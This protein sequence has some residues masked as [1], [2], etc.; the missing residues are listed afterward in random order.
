MEPKSSLPCS[1]EPATDPYPG[2]DEK[3]HTFYPNHFRFILILSPHLH[4]GLPSRAF[5]SGFP[6]KFCYAFLVASMFGTCSDHI[7]SLI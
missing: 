7:I 2:P 5:L 3:M 4:L 1:Q 6:T